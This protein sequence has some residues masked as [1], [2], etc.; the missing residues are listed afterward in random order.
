MSLRLKPAAIVAALCVYFGAAANLPAQSLTPSGR[1][2]FSASLVNGGVSIADPAIAWLGLDIQLEPKWHTYWQSPGDAGAAPEFDWS[3]SE[4]VAAFDIEW[5]AP[6]RISEAGIDSFGYLGRVLLPIRLKLQDTQKPAHIRLKATLYVCATICTSNDIYFEA[7]I[8]PQSGD[9][10]RRDLIAQWRERVPKASSTSM[11]VRSISLK[12]G[13]TSALHIDVAATPPLQDADVFLSGDNTVA[14]ERPRITA[15][16]DGSFAIDLPLIRDGKAPPKDQL[17]LTIVDGDRAITAPVPPEVFGSPGDAKAPDAT[18]PHREAGSLWPILAIALLGG[19]VLNFMPCVFPVLS[20]KVLSLVGN[21]AQEPKTIRFGFLALA[22]GV[23]ASFLALGAALSMLKIAGAEIGWG[24]QF[25]QPIFLFFMVCVLA[26]LTANLIGLFDIRL[27]WRL[28]NAAGHLTGGHSHRAQFF[29]GFVMTLLATPCSAPF[30]GTAVS[31]SLAQGPLQIIAVFSSLGLGMASPYLIAASIPRAARLLPRPGS[32]MMAIR[33]IAA[34]ALAVTAVWLLT[35]L[36]QVANMRTAIAIGATLGVPLWAAAVAQRRFAHVI[37][38]IL[39]IALAGAALVRPGPAELSAPNA[40]V[41]WQPFAPKTIDAMVREGK[42]V[43][44]DIGA[45]W[46]LTCKVNE[47][48]IIDSD[49]IRRR[50]ATDVVPIQADWTKADSTITRY[51]QSHGRYGLP[52]NIVFGPAA[53]TGVVLPEILTETAVLEA[54]G[55]ASGH[56]QLSKGE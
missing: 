41:Q 26:L 39:I 48:F 37:A 20:L 23:I 24:I 38:G 49:A 22:A 28:S 13:E 43:F 3:G 36:A 52:F 30:V 8:A 27:P 53:P 42:T 2:G 4:N 54:F 33:Y 51:L 32:W 5:P 9:E 1:A 10:V 35:V 46:C 19:F 34:G 15:A 21:A 29:N 45:A 50:L 47:A 14:A 17:R 7:A 40:A 56:T 44:V 16:A 31:Y 25:Q 55:R 18:G 12:A 6:R 11:A